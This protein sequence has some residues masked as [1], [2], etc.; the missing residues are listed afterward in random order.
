MLC[1]TDALLPGGMSWAAAD[2]GLLPALATGLGRALSGR[3]IRFDVN[4]RCIRGEL[5]AVWLD[6]RDT[7]FAGRLEL[8]C[9]EYD[10]LRIQH[11]AVAAD[12]VALTAPPDLAIVASGVE[13]RGHATFEAFVA[14]LDR[15]LPDWD[16]RI[17][18]G[19]LVEA[20]S[21]G[22]YRRLLLDGLV[23]D[24]DLEVEIRGVGCRRV[25]LRCPRWL[26]VTRRVRLPALPDD[27]SLAA[28][29]RTGDR[30]EFRLTMPALKYAIDA[31]L[32]REALHVARSGD[33]PR[34]T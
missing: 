19:R 34:P 13:L 32:L 3:R 11:L 30:V 28:V 12:T 17:V 5:H 27:A 29:L 7:H 16:L 24:G 6:R 21:R 23:R 1:S 33:D 15:G 4:G 18:A 14:W 20:V 31:G 25:T 9:A 2:A 22:G 8:R 10:S 26:R